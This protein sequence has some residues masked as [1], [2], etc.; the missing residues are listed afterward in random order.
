MANVNSSNHLKDRVAHIRKMP[1]VFLGF[2]IKCV[3]R[4]T[5]RQRASSK[6]FSLGRVPLAQT[7]AVIDYG[8]YTLPLANSA[9][10]LKYEFTN[11]LMKGGIMHSEF[12]N[13]SFS[14]TNRWK[15]KK[16]HKPNFN[17]TYLLERKDCIAMR[18][19]Y[20]VQAAEAGKLTYK[21]LEACR[22]GLRR[23]LG[24]SAQ[25]L[26]NV[27]PNRPVSS[28]SLAARMG[29]GKGSISHWV[30]IVRQ[31]KILVEVNCVPS[32]TIRF[33]L[34]KAVNKLPLKTKILQLRFQI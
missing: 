9:V 22:R 12:F 27:F 17:F 8:S 30:A 2:K 13:E 11:L 19:E 3:G 7:S 23:G 16:F 31:G 20:A 28:K 15:Y 10:T 1:F 26:F 29:K 14:Y 32:P 6:W 5:R 24:K 18:A 25:L 21:Q 33:A 34:H 4:F